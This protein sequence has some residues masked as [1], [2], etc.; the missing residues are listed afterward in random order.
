[1][2]LLLIPPAIL[3]PVR[4]YTGKQL[5]S[6]ILLSLNIKITYKGKSKVPFNCTDKYT[7]IIKGYLLTGV[8]DKNQLGSVNKSFIH[9]C[10]VIYNKEICN[11]LLSVFSRVFN[12]IMVSDGVSVG[13]K[14]IM[15]CNDFKRSDMIKVC[16]ERGRIKGEGG[17][18]Y[19]GNVL[20]GDMIK[21]VI[22]KDSKLE[23][24]VLEGD[25]IKG[26]SDK[27][28]L[29]GVSDKDSSYKGVSDLTCNLEGDNY[30]TSNYKGNST[31]TNTLHPVNTTTNTLHPVNTT[32]NTLHPV[33][34]TTNTLHPVNTTTNTLHPVNNTSSNYNP[35]NNTTNTLHPVNNST[36]TLH[37]VN[38]STDT[39]NPVNNSTDTYHPVNNSTDTLHPLSNNNS[40]NNPLYL[41]SYIINTLLSNIHIIDFNNTYNIKV[42]SI[43]L[44]I[45][46]IDLYKNIININNKSIYNIKYNLLIDI[47]NRID[48]NML[49]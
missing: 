41:Y 36:D 33:N 45:T 24:N 16:R 6:C 44:N 48:Y 35:V 28:M 42:I 7:L 40:N 18:D 1:T 46:Y 27:G 22:D 31:T 49:I 21:G 30:S 13:I 17:G 23:G 26:V 9:Y 3:R 12:R 43:I 32:T 34:T 29:E 5:I 47:Y 37:P 4:L 20:E 15:L 2:S 19:E 14:D 39:Y 25:M 8:I 10:S 38:N 11:E